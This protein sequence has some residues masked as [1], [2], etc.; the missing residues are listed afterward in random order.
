M[1]IPSAPATALAQHAF[2]AMGGTGRIQLQA[3]PQSSAAIVAAC[4]EIQRLEL[5]YSRYRADSWIS[6]VNAQ[7][8]SSPVACQDEDWALLDF[9][10][11][12]HLQSEGLFDITS[13]VYR[14]AWN[15][16]Q[17]QLPTPQALQALRPLVGWDRVRRHER[18]IFLPTAG[19]Q[20][21]LG[22][23]VKEY[24]VDRACQVLQSHGI[25]SAL[26][27]LAGDVRAIGTKPDGQPWQVGVQHPRQKDR[28]MAHMALTDSAL[29][30]SGDYE[31]YV[32]VQGKR[33][34]HILNPQTG[35]PVQYWQSVSV[36]APSCLLAGSLSSVAMLMGERALAWLQQTGMS[37]LA[38]QPDGTP[39][40]G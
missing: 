4:A 10:D 11:R 25:T 34:T 36:Q 38:V 37:F 5:R 6:Q 39:I 33:Y 28:L 32:E 7:A 40:G 12:L 9:A 2:Q 3:M 17:A 35:W 20:I 13:G 14:R 22:G 31:R 19:M 8:G 26:V 18:S 1:P 15:F 24:A 16:N 30:T 27:N 21:D 23:L 29:A